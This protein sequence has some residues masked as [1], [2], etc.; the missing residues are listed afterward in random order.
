VI[1]TYGG[2]Y[3]RQSFDKVTSPWER[4]GRIK[5]ETESDQTVDPLIKSPG[6]DMH[7]DG[8]RHERTG[9]YGSEVAGER[10]LRAH[11]SGYIG[12]NLEPEFVAP[13]PTSKRPRRST[14]Y[15]DLR[16]HA[17]A[18]P[19]F[20][21]RTGWIA[22]VKELSGLPL[23]RTHNRHGTERVDP[24]PSERRGAIE[25]ALRHFRVI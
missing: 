24:C 22:H 16:A 9:T 20:S 2:R 13:P 4:G 18:R 11:K 17:Y 5:I 3:F 7:T 10:R 15:R 25:E 19:G 23:R 12:T 14:T 6:W 21:T 1:A 8:E